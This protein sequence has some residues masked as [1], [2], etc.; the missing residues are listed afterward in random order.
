LIVRISAVIARDE[1]IAATRRQ[2]M[3]KLEDERYNV[4]NNKNR[5]KRQIE[6]IAN[7]YVMYLFCSCGKLRRPFLALL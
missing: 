5:K 1:A 6:A 7:V 4:H 2:S 3:T